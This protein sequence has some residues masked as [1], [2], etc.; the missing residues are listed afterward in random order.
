MSLGHSPNTLTDV[1]G[2]IHAG[3]DG[4]AQ[5]ITPVDVVNVNV[6]SIEP[7]HGPWV[8]HVEPKAA[9]L[10]TS[11]AALE[12]GTVYVKCVLTAKT[13][14]EAV[15]RNAPMIS[16]G[17][18]TVGLLLSLC[19]LPLLL[20]LTLFRLLRRFGLLLVLSLL[21]LL[22]R[23]GLLLSFRLFRLL[24][25]LGLLLSLSVLL[26]R[27]SLV[28]CRFSLLLLLL[29]LLLL[30]VFFLRVRGSNNAREQ[31]QNCCT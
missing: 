4:I 11:R 23:L 15:V 1:D 3:V 16:R 30:L 5:E 20:V 21:P 26:L 29:R 12:V 18:C 28:L 24:R 14:T 8:Q 22:C 10:K 6:V 13:G 27:L 31:E 9:V 19:R 17:L 25:W 7:P 2:N